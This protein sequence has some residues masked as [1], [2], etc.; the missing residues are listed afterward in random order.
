MY[1]IYCIRNQ[2]MHALSPGGDLSSNPY[3]NSGVIGI[4]DLCLITTVIKKITCL[5]RLFQQ[6][7]HSY[8]MTVF[9]KKLKFCWEIEAVVTKLLD[10][11]LRYEDITKRITIL[12]YHYI[13]MFFVYIR[14]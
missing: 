7:S 10:L 11:F 4:L 2:N 8:A 12:Y 6:P 1:Q 3:D 9:L 5:F 13:Y 14:K